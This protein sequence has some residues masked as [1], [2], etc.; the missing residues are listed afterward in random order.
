MSYANQ[1]PRWMPGKN[2]SLG[3]DEVGWGS[4]AGPLLMCA[5]ALAYPVEGLRDSK[6]LSPSKREKLCELIW[7]SAV[8]VHFAWRDVAFINQHKLGPSWQSVAKECIDWLKAD[9]PGNPI[10]LDGNTSV[11]RVRASDYMLLPHADNLV[12]GCMA[13]SILA[14]VT[15][16]YR[17]DELAKTYKGYDFERSKGYFT[18][19]HVAGIRKLGLC[20]EHR[21]TAS[22]FL[23]K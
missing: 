11:S 19:S 2:L 5:V 20:P 6:L 7:D 14:K 13:S 15:R 3:I 4:G 1:L 22:K 17:M 23:A 9:V 18:P 8:V 12:P 21:Y 10:V 16:D